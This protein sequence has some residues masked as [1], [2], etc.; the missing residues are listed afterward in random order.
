M[1]RAPF[2]NLGEGKLVALWERHVRSLTPASSCRERLFHL[3]VTT[4]G[5]LQVTDGREPRVIQVDDM[6]FHGNETKLPVIRNCNSNRQSAVFNNLSLHDLCLALA[7]DFVLTMLPALPKC[8]FVSG[9]A[10]NT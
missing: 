6:E 3:E 7:I 5:G 10:D 2:G 8:A 9:D 4:Y 1:A